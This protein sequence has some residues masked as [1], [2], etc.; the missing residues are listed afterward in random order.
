ML[1]IQRLLTITIA[2]T[3]SCT[4]TTSCSKDS[5]SITPTQ[6][7]T[8]NVNC[9]DT[10]LYLIPEIDQT[11][12]SNDSD[13]NYTITLSD[14]SSSS[15]TILSRSWE[16]IDLRDIFQTP[17]NAACSATDCTYSGSSSRTGFAETFTISDIGT[18]DDP[19][20]SGN[21]S[22]DDFF[23]KLTVTDS[24]GLSATTTY[25]YSSFNSGSPYF[26]S[27]VISSPKITHSIEGCDL[28]FTINSHD[29]RNDINADINEVWFDLERDETFEFTDTSV[30]I[31]YDYDYD[32]EEDGT[33]RSRFVLVNDAVDAATPDY[34]DF[35]FIEASFKID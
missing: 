31:P 11:S 15:G 24:N 1:N 30:S 28:A 29:F 20:D 27:K 3:I 12:I 5:S 2:V 7:E 22:H 9:A 34:N 18:N 13:T 25:I 35:Y 33:Y 14:I 6:G 26:G 10:S 19:N 8:T 21:Y 17:A 4:L 23:V 16:I 32:Y